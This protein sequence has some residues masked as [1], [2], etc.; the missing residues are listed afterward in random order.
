M[1]HLNLVGHTAAVASL[2]LHRNVLLSGS[3]DGH[4]KLWN[5][6]NFTCTRDAQLGPVF[7]LLSHNDVRSS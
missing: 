1:Y 5:L 3:M 6:Q 7:T 4:L 2:T